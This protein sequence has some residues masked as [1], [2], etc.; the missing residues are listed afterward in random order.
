[1]DHF[2][3]NSRRRSGSLFASS[4]SA[5]RARASCVAA[6]PFPPD[7]WRLIIALLDPAYRV[8]LYCAARAFHAYIMYGEWT[9]WRAMDVYFTDGHANLI[10]YAITKWRWDVSAHSIGLAA[11]KG[12]AH[13]VPPAEIV[14]D[15]EVA[16]ALQMA[17]CRA[18][19]VEQLEGIG[20]WCLDSSSALSA[21]QGGNIDALDWIIDNH[22][23][24]RFES[25]ETYRDMCI[26]KLL[27][28]E[29]FSVVHWLVEEKGVRFDRSRV[30][31]HA[32]HRGDAY[33]YLK[34]AGA[35][36]HHAFISWAS[37]GR[38][39]MLRHVVRLAGGQPMR[40]LCKAFRAAGIAGQTHVLHL[41]LEER[42]L[43]RDVVE[44]PEFRCYSDSI[45]ASTLEWLYS[46]GFRRI[47]I[48]WDYD[49]EE[50]KFVDWG[51]G[52][53]L[54][55]VE[56]VRF[57]ARRLPEFLPK[58]GRHAFVRLQCAADVSLDGRAKCECAEVLFE[59][60][61]GGY[62][63]L[64]EDMIDSRILEH[65]TSREGCIEARLKILKRVQER[66]QAVTALFSHQSI[67]K[68]LRP[69]AE[70]E[71]IAWFAEVAP[72]GSALK[73][74][75]MHYLAEL[76][77]PSRC[78]KR[79]RKVLNASVAR[80]NAYYGGG[81]DSSSAKAARGKRRGKMRK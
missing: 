22:M 28:R 34:F 61:D 43:S 74:S 78:V 44:N 14:P 46:N 45:S 13:L 6:L 48:A 57:C 7:V 36:V 4:N 71:E 56:C 67:D 50:Q 63:R 24:P 75:A 41:M 66:S 77:C 1:M 11:E 69:P 16:S 2:A 23:D 25:D 21:I 27:K 18:G 49:A 31:L 32:A 5:K 73:R 35:Y 70:K 59:L 68:V 79:E 37:H 47:G 19:S 30:A 76:R 8:M 58:K 38:F 62:G 15:P 9:R 60:A 55:T 12:H 51:F 80:L 81:G 29:W 54:Y 26:T 40:E 52:P 64:S 20:A 42:L 72:D 17:Y 53:R 33:Y 39:D 10:R 65:A 3:V